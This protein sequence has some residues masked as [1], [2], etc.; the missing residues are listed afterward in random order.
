M[1]NGPFKTMGLAKLLS[2]FM[3]IA[4]SLLLAVM[5][6]CNLNFSLSY[7]RVLSCKAE[8]LVKVPKKHVLQNSAQILWVLLFAALASPFLLPG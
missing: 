3:G 6:V 7:F 4:L 2:N 8:G 5:S 1:A